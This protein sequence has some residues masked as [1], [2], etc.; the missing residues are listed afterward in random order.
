MKILLIF[1]SYISINYAN[2]IIDDCLYLTSS[3]QYQGNVNAIAFENIDVKKSIEACTKSYKKHPNNAHTLFLLARVFMKDKQYKKGL[4]YATDACN[5]GVVGGCTLL[6]NYY[7]KGII[8]KKNKKKALFIY[9]SSC[10]K[11]DPV[12]CTNL[13]QIK[14]RHDTFA[15]GLIQR[16]SSDLLLRACVLGRYPQACS[17]YA[18]HM[19]NKKIPYD[20]DR[21]EYTAYKACVQGIDSSCILLSD[22]YSTY[23]IADRKSKIAYAKKLSCSTGN[24]KTCQLK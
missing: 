16:K 22:L 17:I 6:A 7:Y 21:Y 13:A 11:G 5:K 19:N 3:V 20:Q 24:K 14:D 2:I 1:L 4:T 10:A 15:H 18:N 8:V 9:L 23:K 12:A